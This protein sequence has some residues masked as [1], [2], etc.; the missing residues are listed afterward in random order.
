MF[1]Y[2]AF[3]LNF[4]SEIEIPEFKIG[5]EPTDVSI[6]IGKTPEK[7]ENPLFPGI[8]I[9]T[10][11]NK[12]LLKVDG[13]AVYYIENGNKIIVEP[14]K[15]ATKDSIRLF[16]LS[17]CM[18][19]VLL[20]R[21]LLPI[22]ASSVCIN[23]KAVLFTGA[24]GIGK[25][26]MASVLRKKGYKTISDDLTLVRID[27]KGKP[28]VISGF[29]QIK[30]WEDTIKKLDENIEDFN[31]I[32]ENINKYKVNVEDD[33]YDEEP[34]DIEAVYI[35]NADSDDGF[36]KV[37]LKGLEKVNALTLNTSRPNYVKG[38]GKKGVNFKQVSILGNNTRVVKI[39]RKRDTFVA[40]EF[41]D[42]VLEDINNG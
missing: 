18:I 41:A 17:S 20:Q 2:K 34:L 22:H 37:K 40:N 16:L 11:E 5:V 33:F 27:E 1:L 6:L 15:D 32:R 35:L 7:L 19:A 13:I 4:N 10:A 38:L 12:L 26:T 8:R 30:L 29:P 21:D 23:G 39:T 36:K 28:K 9:Q 42:F 3:G 24:S 31:Q 14:D 25:S